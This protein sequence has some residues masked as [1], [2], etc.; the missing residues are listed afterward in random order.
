MDSKYFSIGELE[1]FK[2]RFKKKIQS[3]SFQN[4]SD[5]DKNR[6]SREWEAIHSSV[7]SAMITS[8]FKSLLSSK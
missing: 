8:N 6:S 2:F 4:R 7:W 3:D 1:N 5:K